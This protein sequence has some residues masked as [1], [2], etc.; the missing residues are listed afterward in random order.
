[1]EKQGELLEIQVCWTEKLEVF[2][3]QKTYISIRPKEKEVLFGVSTQSQGKSPWER[4]PRGKEDGAA[5]LLKAR[6]GFRH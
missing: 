2:E 4:V 5:G 3:M 6:M 1:M